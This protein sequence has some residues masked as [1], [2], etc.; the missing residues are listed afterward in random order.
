L[1]RRPEAPGD[2]VIVTATGAETEELEDLGEAEAAIV[3]RQSLMET[4][5]PWT[6]E[7]MEESRDFFGETG[8]TVDPP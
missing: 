2:V 7:I 1:F 3:G 6:G 8:E 4:N 5:T